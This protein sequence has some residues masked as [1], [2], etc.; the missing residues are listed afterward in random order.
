MTKIIFI[1][2]SLNVTSFV[3]CDKSASVVGQISGQLVNPKNNKEGL[4]L[5]VV[6]LK[7]CPL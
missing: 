1:E 7:A 5:S 4:F 6:L 3:I 2:S